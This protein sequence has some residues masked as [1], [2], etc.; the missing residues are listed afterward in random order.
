MK[1]LKLANQEENSVVQGF[2]D[3]I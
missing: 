3:L 1:V 2:A